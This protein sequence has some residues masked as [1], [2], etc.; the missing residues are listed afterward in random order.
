MA[1]TA[2]KRRSSTP[3]S[4]SQAVTVASGLIATGGIEAVTMRVVAAQLG[5]SVGTLTYHFKSKQELLDEV[6]LEMTE[7]RSARF[8]SVRFD[9]DFIAQIM[10]MFERFLPLDSETDNEW[11]LNMVYWGQSLPSDSNEKSIIY[12]TL[13]SAHEVA[14]GIFQGALDSGAISTKQSA[15]ELADQ[16]T[17]ITTG[18][19]FSL[20][21]MPMSKRRAQLTIIQNF[22]DNI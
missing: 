1:T 9:G 20:L 6:F 17:Q 4:R 8:N 2:T 15:A 14:E 18:L 12:D 19:G 11:R 3:I 7:A 5:C 10:S 13:L 21:H 16:L 22:L